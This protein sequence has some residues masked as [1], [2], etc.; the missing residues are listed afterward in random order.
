MNLKK[1]TIIGIVAGEESGDMLGAHLIKSLKK[2]SN[3]SFIGVTGPLMKKEGCKTLYSINEINI[4]GIF[5]IIKKIPKIIKIRYKLINFFN[6][7]KIDVFIG[8]DSP[9]FNI[10]IEKKLKKKGIKTIHYVS[11]SVWAWRKN[12]IIKIKKSVNLILILFYFEKKIYDFYK[13]PYVFVSH[14]KADHMPIKPNKN[15][16]RKR[17]KIDKNKKCLVL[18]PGS[19]IS[20]I[21][22]LSKKFLLT[23][24]ILIKKNPNLVIFVSLTKNQK[25]IKKFKQISKKIKK[26]IPIKILYGKTTQIIP[27]ADVA[28]AASGTVTLECMLA[29]CPMVVAYKIN[30][31]TYFFIKHF[32]KIP[33]FSL[34]NLLSGKKIVQ[35]F[36]Q[37][38]C[39]VKNLSKSIQSLLINK[40][41]VNKI[42]KIFFKIHKNIKINSKKKTY[43]AILMIINKT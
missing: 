5:E 19:R 14:F 34:P 9:D 30:R 37:N 1:K 41:K 35:E 24:D 2:N 42:K 12:R 18:L 32:I 7:I 21:K 8:I 20:E 3:I 25:C 22:M 43:K 4:M 23:A 13:I 28:L 11:P 6:K 27:A 17:F 29:K 38:K 36:I 40:K 26:K 10:F 39:K 31:I 15:K 16:F 33:F